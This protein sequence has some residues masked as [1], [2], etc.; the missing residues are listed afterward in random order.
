MYSIIFFS[1]F[2][3]L[4][5]LLFLLFG[6]VISILSCAGPSYRQNHEGQVYQPRPH[7]GTDV[8]HI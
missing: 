2:S 6:Q 1:F 4:Y 5:L 8:G 7:S 3:F